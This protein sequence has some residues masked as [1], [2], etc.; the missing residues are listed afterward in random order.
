MSGDFTQNMETPVW[1]KK[2]IVYFTP[3][4]NSSP[5]VLDIY[6]VEGMILD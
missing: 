1:T 4:V 3:R 6:Q 2:A 5:I